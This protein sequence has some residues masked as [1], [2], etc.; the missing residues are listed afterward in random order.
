MERLDKILANAMVGSRKEVVKLIRSGAVTVNETVITDPAT[1]VNPD[2]ADIIASGIPVCYREHYHLMMNKPDGYICATEDLREKTVL[3][4]LPDDEVPKNKVFP[5]GRL[6]KDTEGFVFLTTDGKLAHRVTGPKN[7]VNKKYFVQIDKPMIPE[8]I[9][10]FKSGITIDDGYECKSAFLEI[11]SE[12]TCHLT[13]FEGKFHQVKR[14]FE[15]LGA[16]VTYLKRVQIGSLLL[17]DSLK[18]G[19][20]RELT[21]AEI[22]LLEIVPEEYKENL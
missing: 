7:H 14:M 18:L 11:L 2:E 22:T 10:K 19:E 17:D 3:D 20:Y 1:K 21:P 12:N 16:T 9:A 5:A 8:W 15:A 13:I 6:D 4:L